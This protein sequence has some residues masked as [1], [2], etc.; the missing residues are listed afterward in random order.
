MAATLMGQYQAVTQDFIAKVKVGLLAEAMVISNE[1]T[2]TPNHANRAA[3]MKL[4]AQNPD[5]YATTVAFLLASQGIDNTSTDAAIATAI[6][7][8]WN[9]LAGVP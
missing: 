2:S 9:A 1:S 8:V 6:H 3:L 7:N 4:V 5:Q